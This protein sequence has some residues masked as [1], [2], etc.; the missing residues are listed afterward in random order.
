MILPMFIILIQLLIRTRDI[1][2]EWNEWVEKQAKKLHEG[3]FWYAMQEIEGRREIL[4]K[5]AKNKAVYNL[6]LLIAAAF[7]GMNSAQ[8]G[9]QWFYSSGGKPANSSSGSLG[10]QTSSNSLPFGY[11]D[12]ALTSPYFAGGFPNG[13]GSQIGVGTDTTTQ[14]TPTMGNLVAQVAS[15]ALSIGPNLNANNQIQAS[16]TFPAG[17][18]GAANTNKDIGEIGLQVIQN[19]YASLFT[20]LSVAD[21]E[22]LGNGNGSI[23]TINNNFPAVFSMILSTF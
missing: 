16:A 17:S 2:M 10:F 3:C 8:L 22:N 1:G 20:R 6:N 11:Y 21:N 7:S 4:L 13:G 9:T 23:I 15:E 19:G 14:T 18:L 5:G 12:S